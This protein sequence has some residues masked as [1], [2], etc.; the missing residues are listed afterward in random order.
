LAE[1]V[2]GPL[3]PRRR[4]ASTL[5]RLRERSRK[6]LEEVSV[7]LLIS[8]SKL[9][10]LENAQGKPQARDIRDLIRYYGI[11]GTKQADNLYRWVDTANEPGWWTD[12]DDEVIKGLDAHLAYEADATV[13]RVYTL[14]FL[15]A[16]LQIPEYAST[17]FRDM[18]G[19][20]EEEIE[21]LL[22]V[23]QQRQA[24]L[25][26]RP[27]M[28]DMAPLELVAVTHESTLRQAVGS[29][30]VMHAQLEA[31][32]ERSELPNVHLHVL[33]FESRPVFS[34]TCMYA[35]FEYKEPEDAGQDIVH[36]E[37]PA[38]FFSIDGPEDVARYRRAHHDLV[39]LSLNETGS[40]AM[41]HSVRD[42]L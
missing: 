41:I 40:R 22:A 20:S 10:R 13:A 19:R 31:L 23:R 9:S 3:G 33:P 24:A 37:T 6:T 39:S 7:D 21:Q 25:S 26:G 34:M 42:S 11:D 38:G 2:T 18:G 16:L 35:Y 28:P 15:P 14:P 30:R 17:V 4:I 12:Y 1:K 5:R 29:R 32:I 36:I 27:D 8:T